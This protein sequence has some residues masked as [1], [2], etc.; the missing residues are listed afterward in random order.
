MSKRGDNVSWSQDAG[1][2]VP[3][4]FYYNWETRDDILSCKGQEVLT[5]N[6]L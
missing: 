4:I 1:E 5:K 2:N 6:F 3:I